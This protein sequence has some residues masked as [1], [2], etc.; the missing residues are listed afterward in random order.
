MNTSTFKISNVKDNYLYILRRQKKIHL[1]EIILLEGHI[2][3][4]HIYLQN[5]RKMMIAKTLKSLEGI[6][7][8]HHFYRIHRGILI[9]SNHLKAYDS[10]LGEALLTNNHKVTASR[11]KKMAFENMII[12]KKASKI[13]K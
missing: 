5:G 3:Y 10:A 11:R 4:T 13:I 2:N 6:L 12:R 1:S 7:T 9:N 8:S